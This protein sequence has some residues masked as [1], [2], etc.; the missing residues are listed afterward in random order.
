MRTNIGNL[1][2]RFKKIDDRFKRIDHLDGAP[3]IKPAI[4]A[5]P[6][7]LEKEIWIKANLLT[8]GIRF[9][10]SALEGICSVYKEQSRWLFDWNMGDHHYYLPE[11]LLLPMDTTCQVRENRNSPWLCTVEDG[12][13]MLKRDGKFVI[14]ARHIPR[15]KYYGLE[16][17]EG[18]IMRRIAPKRGQDCLVLNYAP[19][20]MYWATNDG[21]SFCNIVPNM[22]WTK[23]DL[24][25]SKR[26][27]EQIVK[28]AKAAFEE[29]AVRH[30]LLTGGFMTRGK[31]EGVDVDLEDEMI[32][33][34][35]RAMQE[36]IG[37][38]DIPVNV[39]RTV[40]KDE[41]LKSIERY[42]KLGFYSVAYNLEI[43]DPA[44]FA[45]Y[46]SGKDKV[47]GRDHWLRGLETATEVYGPGKVSTHFVTGFM[48][49]EAS[50]L[51]GVE[52]CSQRGIGVIPLIWSPVVG[53]SYEDFRTPVAEWF[54]KMVK[55]IADIRLK[56]DV[57]AFNPAGL[58]NDDH[59]CGMPS[60]IADEL[61]LRKLEREQSEAKKAA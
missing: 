16:A 54:V 53:T 8:E 17:S 42:K 7:G 32:L 13:L 30:I 2:S 25:I 57:D 10:E 31:K 34:V 61:L 6:E 23:D 24:Q 28:T 1:D 44:L 3:H 39:I 29:G 56:Y 47:Q 45:R 9:D 21:C 14:E 22:K 19:F 60:L 37:T 18:V 26:S 38:N 4:K 51:E 48:E 55:K 50:L 15:P 43:W 49:P 33:S 40:P 11:E 5:T 58:P 20:C 52:W 35:V 59:I 36:G 27:Y 46:C 12:V 41:D